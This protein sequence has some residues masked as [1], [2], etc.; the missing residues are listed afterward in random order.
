MNHLP[1]KEWLLSDEPLTE[2]QSQVFAEH[3]RTCEECRQTQNAW[4][5]VRGLFQH[6][7]QSAPKDGFTDR[8]LERMSARRV[9]QQRMLLG[10][11]AAVGILAALAALLLLSAQLTILFQSPTRF[12]LLCLTQLASVLV[13]MSSLQDYLFVI[14]KNIP[15]I[16][17]VGLL[18]TLGLISLLGVLWLT[19]FQQLVIA[20]R[21]SK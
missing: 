1:F 20:R 17:V 3:L 10:V 13:V 9:R 16:P 18:L 6:T 12:L 5:D 11:A 21:F 2:D 8:W 19:T 4:A 7:V 14:F 15:L